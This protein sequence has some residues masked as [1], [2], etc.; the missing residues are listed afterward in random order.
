[1]CC[2]TASSSIRACSPARRSRR[3][4]ISRHAAP[5]DELFRRAGQLTMGG[6]APGHPMDWSP[7]AGTGLVPRLYGRLLAA[8]GDLARDRAIGADFFFKQKTAYEI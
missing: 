2:R 8:D 5:G 6:Q 3:P 4:P 1:M 7:A